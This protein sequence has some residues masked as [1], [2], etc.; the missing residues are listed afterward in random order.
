[1]PLRHKILLCQ[2][3]VAWTSHF[4]CNCQIAAFYQFITNHKGCGSHELGLLISSIQQ[5]KFSFLQQN[6]FSF[7]PVFSPKS[8]DTLDFPLRYLRRAGWLLLLV[9]S[10]MV[11]LFSFLFHLA[12]YPSWNGK[13]QCCDWQ[14][15]KKRGGKTVLKGDL[16]YQINRS[17]I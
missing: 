3:C 14:G 1:M 13:G 4:F 10:G 11:F 8:Q 12:S 2:L 5:E 7:L 9:F 16:N 6:L 15:S 17:Q